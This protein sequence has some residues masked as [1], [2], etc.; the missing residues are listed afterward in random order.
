MK[1]KVFLSW[2]GQPSLRV[3][4]ALREWIRNVLPSVETWMSEEDIAVGSRWAN[5]L[6]HELESTNACI[7]CLTP[8]NMNSTWLHFEA[9][10]VAKVVQD[11][12]VCPFLFGVTK[13]ELIGPLAQ[14]QSAEANRA[15][16]LRLVRGLN[17]SPGGPAIERDRL[18]KMFEVWWPC[19]DNELRSIDLYSRRNFD[20]IKQGI[21]A[22]IHSSN[23]PMYFVDSQLIV[24]DCNDDLVSLLNSTATAIVGEHLSV[25][26][27]RFGSRVPESRR[28]KFLES[29]LA[30]ADMAAAD[31]GPHLEAVEYIDNRDLL[32]N[33]YDRLYRVW[34][35]ADKVSSEKGGD[36]Y[37]AFVIY[38]VERLS[39]NAK[40]PLNVK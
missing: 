39:D 4:R 29:N 15:D 20:I 33:R 1:L 21:A 30:L 13:A 34:I 26:I 23:L 16:T 14:F 35:H 37:G 24:Q 10:E 22:L 11:S 6:S 25:L 40:I 31:L 2:S 17:E 18:D 9:G 3:A 32:G 5:K 36:V 28:T 7:L 8:D 12:L 19:L 27:R 38:R